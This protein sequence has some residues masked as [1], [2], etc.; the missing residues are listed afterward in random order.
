MTGGQAVDGPLD[1][2]MI[3]RQVAA[4]GVQRIVVV[5]DEPEKYPAGTNWAPGSRVSG[6]SMRMPRPL[7]RATSVS[8][9]AS[10][11]AGRERS[12]RRPSGARRAWRSEEHTSE[13]QSLMRISYAVFCL[14]KK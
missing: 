5:T 3:S 10:R 7:R 8:T 4:E 1:P 2:A 12:W 9:W 14:K 11:R 13:I 6:G